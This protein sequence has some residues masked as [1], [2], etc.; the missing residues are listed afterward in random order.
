MPPEVLDDS[1]KTQWFEAYK[2]ADMYSFALVL[3]EIGRRYIHTT[4]LSYIKLVWRNEWILN[5]YSWLFISRCLTEA[6]DEKVEC[7]DYDTPY[8]ECVPSDPSFE[9]MKNVICDHGLRPEIPTRWNKSKV[10]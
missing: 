8:S 3:W 6:G 1:M 4:Y 7:E 9:E 10:I 2:Q 5:V